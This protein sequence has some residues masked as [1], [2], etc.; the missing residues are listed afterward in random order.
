MQVL[1]A[2]EGESRKPDEN[3]TPPVLGETERDKVAT[4]IMK[5]HEFV[6][7]SFHM[8]ASCEACTKP[9]WAPFRPPPAV[10]CRSEL[11][12]NYFLS[13]NCRIITSSPCCTLL[14]LL[15]ALITSV[16]S[17]G[18]RI[19]LH[20]EHTS[21]AGEGLTP[22][23]VSYDPT[24]AKEMLLMAASVEEQQFWV[25]RL[26]KKIQKGGFKAAGQETGSQGSK[27]SPQESMRSQY[28]PTVQVIMAR[29]AKSFEH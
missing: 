17:L 16:F 4:I 11:R 10:E 28:K 12:K 25:A 26:L 15:L 9:L 13:A 18:C 5:G 21:G 1:Y 6:T 27:I 22:C 24:T 20:K 14:N 29:N 23:K 8:P 3:A 7:I 19:K 2:G